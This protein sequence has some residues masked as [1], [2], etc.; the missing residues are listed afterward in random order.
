MADDNGRVEVDAT[1]A[2]AGSTPGVTRY[3]LAVSLILIIA[4]FAFLFMR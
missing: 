1:D 3:V 4:V 2:R